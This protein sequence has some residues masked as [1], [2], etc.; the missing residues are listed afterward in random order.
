MPEEEV[1]NLPLA[2]CNKGGTRHLFIT[3]FVAVFII[4]SKF[5][6]IFF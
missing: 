4:I 3:A 1:N 6:Y 2:G 5:V